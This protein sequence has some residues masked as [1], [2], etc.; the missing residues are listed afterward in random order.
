MEFGNKLK[1]L[2]V[3]HHLTQEE[4]SRRLL[5]STPVYNRHEN[6]IKNIKDADII[7]DRLVNEFNVTREWL[8]NENSDLTNWSNE[9]ANKDATDTLFYKVPKEMM[10]FFAR[11]QTIMEKILLLIK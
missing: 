10:D 7:L 2:R 11:Q 4:M 1:L 6:G 3:L 8:L 5:L 9:A